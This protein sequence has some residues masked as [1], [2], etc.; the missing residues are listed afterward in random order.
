VCSLSTHSYRSKK[1]DTERLNQEYSKLVE[2]FKDTNTESNPILSNDLLNEAIPGNIRKM[3]HF[4]G[5]LK[6]FTEFIKHRL[7]EVS[8]GNW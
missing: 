8:K 1:K 3:D 7:Q 2:G 5:F 4:L 6:R